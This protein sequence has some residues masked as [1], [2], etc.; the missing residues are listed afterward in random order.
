MIQQNTTEWYARN[1][2]W[3]RAGRSDHHAGAVI[4]GLYKSGN[5]DITSDVTTYGMNV[6]GHTLYVSWAQGVNAFPQSSWVN[7]FSLAGGI[8][9]YV[10][11][12]KVYGA[13]PPGAYPAPNATMGFW[14]SQQFYGWTQVTSGSMDQFLDDM[15][16]KVKTLPYNI[17]IQITSERDTDHQFGGTINGTSYTWAQLDALSVAGVSYIINRFRGR[18]VTNATFSAGM[19]GFA[20]AAAAFPRCYCPDVDIIQF[21]SY[22]HST[23]R[24]PDEVFHEQYDLL[25]SLPA[26][27]ETKPVW[28]AEWGCDPDARR[29]AYLRAVPAAIAKMSR[30]AFMSYFNGTWG[31]IDPS[32]TASLIALADCFNDPLYGGTG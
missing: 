5:A 20:S 11:E 26:G 13:T 17:N 30:I 12:M 23:W 9:N 29:P 27:N 4:G 1:G 10:W 32:D 16:D 31:T 21:N 19:A 6:K 15:A 25:A 18:G 14:G 24:T 2:V 28:I 8:A 3:K 22:N 7:N